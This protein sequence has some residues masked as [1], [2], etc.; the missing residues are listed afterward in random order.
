MSVRLKTVWSAGFLTLLLA[1][2]LSVDGTRPDSY[3]PGAGEEF[4]RPDG[5]EGEELRTLAQTMRAKNRIAEQVA[6]RRFGLLEGAAALRAVDAAWPGRG[7]ARVG[8][9]YPDCSEEEA[10]CRAMICWVG[11]ILA[12]WQTDSTLAEEL[13]AELSRRL[14]GPEP[15]R[16]PEV[17][18]ARYLP[19][20]LLPPAEAPLAPTGQRARG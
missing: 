15:L 3:P 8:R 10:Y 20:D 7:R 17:D 6:R 2:I 19:P 13:N 1:G 9:Q 16:L 12:D 11:P 18:L 4:L 14:N 5:R